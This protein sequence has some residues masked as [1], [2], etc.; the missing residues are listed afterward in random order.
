[1]ATDINILVIALLAIIVLLAV[2]VIRLEI[3]MRKLLS[4]KNAAS[5]EDTFNA[6]AND[7]KELQMAR[8]DIESYLRTVEERL[9]RSIQGVQTVRFNPFKDVSIG[10]NQS[11]AT[12]LVDEEGNGVVISSL[13]SRDRVSVYSKP[14][15]NNSSEYGLTNEEREAIEKARPQKVQ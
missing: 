6:L 5:L 3:R 14:L 1:M 15:K 7:L 2:W 12:A 11:F 4:G 10:S 8:R 13:Y 9:K